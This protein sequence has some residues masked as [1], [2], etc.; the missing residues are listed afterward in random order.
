MAKILSPLTMEPPG[1]DPHKRKLEALLGEGAVKLGA[2]SISLVT[3]Y[4]VDGAHKLHFSLT[5]TEAS[6][7]AKRARYS[8]PLRHTIFRKE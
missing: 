5:S 6:Q 7:D 2:H 8:R 1:E 4:F 3:I